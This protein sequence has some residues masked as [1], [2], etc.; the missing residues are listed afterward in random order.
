MKVIRLKYVDYKGLKTMCYA[1]GLPG[2]RCQDYRTTGA[3]CRRE[4]YVVAGVAYFWKQ[5]D[6]LYHSVVAEGL[7]RVFEDFESFRSE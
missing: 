1:C 3:R 2:D 7:G 6:S 5:W 4:N